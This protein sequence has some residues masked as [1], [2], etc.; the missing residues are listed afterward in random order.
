MVSVS[1]AGGAP[2]EGRPRDESERH[3]GGRASRGRGMKKRCRWK[4]MENDVHVDTVHV[5]RNCL[6][7][8]S[9]FPLYSYRGCMERGQD[10]L[11]NANSPRSNSNQ[12]RPE[13][14]KQVQHPE[15]NLSKSCPH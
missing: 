3:R 11:S 14:P 10:K 1:V 6:M 4:E 7:N 8:F 13:L 2:E 15:S 12:I 9:A 5:E